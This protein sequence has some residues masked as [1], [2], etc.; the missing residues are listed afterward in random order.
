MRKK[1]MTS[2]ICSFLV[3]NSNTTILTANAVDFAP[4]PY[5]S[6]NS[7]YDR[8]V[9]EAKSGQAKDL[10][11]LEKALNLLEDA[12]Y[13]T[14]I[15]AA[16]LESG[17]NYEAIQDFDKIINLFNDAIIY[18][19]KIDANSVVSQELAG[20]A[21]RKELKRVLGYYYHDRGLAKHRLER[22]F[23]AIQDFDKAIELNPNNASAYVN[24]G[25]AKSLLGHHSE[26][27]NDI[28]K[29]IELDPNNA[30][31]YY[32]RGAT[33]LR[34]LQPFLVIK[35]LDKAIEL[36]PNKADYYVARGAAKLMLKQSTEAMKDVDKAISLDPNN[37]RAY[38]LKAWI[39]RFMSI[40]K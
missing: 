27:I 17:R 7:Y 9:E 24:R 13:L 32:F 4:T 34:L 23:E 16:K 36:D 2:I 10:Q 6:N 35:D 26:G 3:L 39:K 5:S 22:Y 8:G 25:L 18:L 12:M 15:A 31:A 40:S 21:D 20:K 14:D 19:D 33:N 38:E 30:S 29:A 11:N 37:T 1:L 28:D